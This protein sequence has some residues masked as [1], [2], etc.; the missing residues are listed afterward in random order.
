[1]LDIQEMTFKEVFAQL[2][3]SLRNCDVLPVLGAG[4]T[5]HCKTGRDGEV[6]SGKDCKEQMLELIRETKKLDMHA[7]NDLATRDLKDVSEIFNS[8]VPESL[9]LAYFKKNF[10][11]V[12]LGKNKKK[13]LEIGWDYIYTLNIDDA[14]ERNSSYDYVIPVTD[15]TIRDEVFKDEKCIIKLHGD[16]KDYM[17]YEDGNDLVFSET[18]YLKLLMANYQIMNRLKHDMKYKNIIY[19]GCSLDGELDILGVTASISEKDIQ[20]TVKYYFTADTINSVQKIRLKKY[21][22]SHIVKFDSFDDIYKQLVMAWEEAGKVCVNDLD[23]LGKMKFQV[24]ESTTYEEN[25]GYLFFGKNLIQKTENF[26][27]LLL[28]YYFIEREV[29]N[30]IIKAL[31]NRT[32]L[33]LKGHSCS[34]KT[35]ILYDIARRIKNFNVLLFQSKDRLSDLAVE[36]LMQYHNSIFL[37]DELSLNIHQFDYLME[38][39]SVLKNNQIHILIVTNVR[40][41]EISNRIDDMIQNC[42]LIKQDVFQLQNCFLDNERENISKKLLRCA[43]G[44]FRETSLLDN[45]ISLGNKHQE[46]HRYQNIIP[47]HK[48]IKEFAV[49][50]VLAMQHKIYSYQAVQ[51]DFVSEVI[52]QVEH[53]HPM[54]EEELTFDFER[55]AEDNSSCKYVINAEYWLHLWLSHFATREN[56]IFISKAFSYIMKKII[57]HNGVNSINNIKNKLYKRYIW[58]DN[59]NQL[60]DLLHDDKIMLIKVIYDDLDSLLYLEPSYNHQRAKAYVR[61]AYY[62]LRH[63]DASQAEVYLRN[64]LH[65]V[66][67]AI[68]IYQKIFDDSGNDK[69]KISLDHAIYTHAVILCHLV[70]L[71]D[72]NQIDEIRAMLETLYKAFLSPNNSYSYAKK[73]T[74]NFNNVLVDTL[75]YLSRNH[76]ELDAPYTSYLEYL[77]NEIFSQR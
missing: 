33:I 11:K 2:V 61:C 24:I 29:T 5:M 32:V 45:I 31:Q 12:K 28:P 72:Y 70:K 21:K 20:N 34:G 74:L 26:P 25:K 57:D 15:K 1:M 27:V 67:G 7:M 75:N 10:S 54:I 16:I 22:I 56:F 43:L 19:I 77:I 46:E 40:T 3:S 14:I 44:G 36:N 60:F 68:E 9:R 50:I 76:A 49:L 65:F 48:T 73:D 38:Q 64:A 37:F 35:Y 8:L 42:T 39:K 69:V 66:I 51:F 6:P 55:D 4:F 71:H 52:A 63:T 23:A 58:F 13:F 47:L 41:N 17:T 62:A 30:Y 59:I 18:S 53:A